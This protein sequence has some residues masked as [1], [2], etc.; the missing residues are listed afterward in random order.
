MDKH[1][2]K[3]IYPIDIRWNGRILARLSLLLVL[4]LVGPGAYAQAVAPRPTVTRAIDVFESN[5]ERVIAG[6]RL[7]FKTKAIAAAQ[8]IVR[9]GLQARVFA[10]RDNESRP[11]PLTR[12][13]DCDVFLSVVLKVESSGGTE[14]VVQTLDH[15]WLNMSDSLSSIV[16]GKYLFV[17]EQSGP[18]S[19]Q[20]RLKKSDYKAY[21]E[22]GFRLVVD[23]HDGISL[24]AVRSEYF[25]KRD[26]LGVLRL[27]IDEK[28]PSVPC[29]TYRP[30]VAETSV[31]TQIAQS[32]MEYCEGEVNVEASL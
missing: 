7:A 27:E 31:V 9:S 19:E 1:T 25:K 16:P 4:L 21:F 13:D 20:F 26:R 2:D 5:P 11:T 29:Y 10:L 15:G 32:A 24:E 14:A 17:F 6:S 22:T 30:L 12:I 18:A 23:K 8:K 28:Q 3:Q